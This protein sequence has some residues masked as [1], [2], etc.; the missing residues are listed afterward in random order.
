LTSGKRL[1]RSSRRTEEKKNAEPPESRKDKNRDKDVLVIDCMNLVS[2]TVFAMP[3]MN[4][5]RDETGV[6]Y[7]FLRQIRSLADR[8]KTSR[9]VFCWDSRDN[10]RKKVNPEYKANRRKNLTEE[11]ASFWQRAFDQA[12]IL[13]TEVLYDLGFE[14]VY[15]QIGYEA[16]D[17]IAHVVQRF[18][19]NYVIVSSDNDLWQLLEKTYLYETRCYSIRNSKMMTKDTFFKAFGIEPRKWAMVKAI[20]G[21]SSDNVKGVERVGE[22]LALRYI[23]KQLD[24]TGKVYQKIRAHEDLINRNLNLVALPFA[25]KHEIRIRE[26]PVFPPLM[27]E[28]FEKVFDRFEFKSLKNHFDKWSNAFELVPF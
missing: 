23:L 24:V 20:A 8:F 6:I 28:N 22:V 15:Y 3:E 5:E 19:D 21:C 12:K 27:V 10:Y 18:P 11:E 2:A 1:N 17:L 4:T 9:F 25:H 13:R 26:F 7:G 16:D 14:N